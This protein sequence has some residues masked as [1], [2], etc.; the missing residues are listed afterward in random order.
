MT[1]VCV[2]VGVNGDVVTVGQILRSARRNH[3]VN[4]LDKIAGELC[5]RPYYLA[6][7]EQDNFTSFPSACYASGFL[8]NYSSYLGLN[9]NDIIDKYKQEYTGASEEVTLDFPDVA[10]PGDF[11]FRTFA[12]YAGVGLLVVCGVWFSFN[13]PAVRDVAIQDQNV[14]IQEMG[15][16]AEKPQVTADVTSEKSNGFSLISKAEASVS[17]V[18]APRS[19]SVNLTAR[20][21]AWVRVVGPEGKIFIDRILRKGEEFHAPDAKGLILMT[22]NAAALALDMGDT[23]MPSLG[24]QG[25]IVENL[26]L[27]QENLVQLASSL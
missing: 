14:A 5:I 11:S 4:D 1:T 3:R 21:D 24:K 2:D 15:S 22:S 12:S 20:E 17:K 23:S 7:L 27:E 18:F 16:P 10:V 9:A 26:S 13:Q 8:R 6:A 19:A 25:Q